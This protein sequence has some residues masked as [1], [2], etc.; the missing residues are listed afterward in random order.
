MK[1][2]FL[3]NFWFSWDKSDCNQLKCAPNGLCEFSILDLLH[4][5]S[6]CEKKF[7]IKENYGLLIS[8]IFLRIISTLTEFSYLN[9]PI[10][11]IVLKIGFFS[12]SNNNLMEFLYNRLNFIFRAF[13]NSSGIFEYHFTND[14]IIIILI[15]LNFVFFFGNG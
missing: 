3:R 13:K 11:F 8:I 15:L 6:F 2:Y 14:S 12:T 1:N 10:L 9:N 4:N 7:L 5:K